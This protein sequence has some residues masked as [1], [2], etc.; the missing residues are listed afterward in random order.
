LANK[1]QIFTHERRLEY[2]SKNIKLYPSEP[3]DVKERAD[4]DKETIT[5]FDKFDNILVGIMDQFAENG[6]D[7]TALRQARAIVIQNDPPVKQAPPM[8]SYIATDITA[9]L[10]KLA[11]QIDDSGKLVH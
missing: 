1:L 7:V 3:A 4:F 6:L 11:E 9:E 5:M 10:R 2:D 8:F